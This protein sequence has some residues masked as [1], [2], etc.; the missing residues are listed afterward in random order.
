MNWQTFYRQTLR[1]IVLWLPLAAVIG[2]CAGLTSALLL[3]SLDWA[4]ATRVANPV[5]ILFLPFAGLLVGWVYYEWGRDIESGNNLLIDEIHQPRA[6]TQLR[7]MPLIFIGTVFSHLF[8][9]SVGREGTAV[10][11]S[12]AL[13]DQIALITKRKVQDRRVIL[14]AAMSAGFAG[15]FGTPLAGAVFGLEVQALGKMRNNALFPCLIASLVSD[16]LVRSLGVHHTHYVIPSI[17]SV[18]IMGLLAVLFAGALF[19]LAGK[20]FAELTHWVARHFKR[21]KYPPL[22]PFVGGICV[23]S[24]V[25]IFGAERYIGL[26]IPS[27]VE[28]FN[29]PIPFWDAPLKL[30][31]TTLSL[32]AG[33]KGGEVT[34]L[35][36]IGA[37]MGN[38]LA[39]LLNMP[40]PLLAGLGFVAVFA[41]AANTPL[42]CTLM[43]IELFGAAIGPYALLACVVAF[44]FSGHSSIYV[45]Q[46]WGS[47]KGR[48]MT[49]DKSE[50]R[51]SDLTEIK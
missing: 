43:A 21:I 48:P 36:Y 49:D 1:D 41:G 30:F 4:T 33:F 31:F 20:S 47:G 24:L 35:F 6:I 7:M 12:G 25:L 42:T 11:M 45:A 32:G 10:Q 44:L 2:L 38:A 8:G 3:V 46:R 18:T 15:V 14:M 51:L 50:V 27:I 16:W 40:F 23:A 19:G 9:A 34:P 39:P 5:L 13:A 28:S 26:G 22:R 29:Q 17:P 37:T